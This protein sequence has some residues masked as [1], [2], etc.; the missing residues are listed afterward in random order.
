MK[1]KTFLLVCGIFVLLSCQAKESI[2]IYAYPASIYDDARCSVYQDFQTDLTFTFHYVG[3]KITDLRSGG[4]KFFVELPEELKLLEASLMDGWKKPNEHYTSFPVSPAE[5][6]GRKYLRY[7]L[8]VP[9]SVLQPALTKPLPG[10]MFGGTTNNLVVL[11]VK[12]DKPMPENSKVY[13]ET[14][15]QYPYQGEFRIYPVKLPEGK[16]PKTR[17]ALQSQTHLPNLGYSDSAI[18]EQIRLFR[19]LNISAVNAQMPSGPNQGRKELWKSAGFSFYGGGSLMHVFWS[20]G[21]DEDSTGKAEERDYLAGLDGLRS[22]GVDRR[23]YHMRTFCP[24]AM[25]TPGRYPYR[26]LIRLGR[27]AAEAGSMFLDIDIE[28]DLCIMCYCPECL[29]AFFRFS[30]L[31]PEKLEPEQLVRKY[32]EQWYRF[33]SEQTRLLYQA[34]RNELKGDYPGIQIGANTVL[35][36]FGEDFGNLKYGICEFA[37]DPRLMKESL[38]FIMADTLV[39]GLY[40]AV[41]VDALA[42]SSSLPVIAIPGSSYCVGYSHANFAG[43]RQTA[44]MTGDTYGYGQRYEYHKLGMLHLA[45]NG[46]SALRY[47]IDEACVAKATAEALLIL[48]NV[49]DFYLDG[50][51]ADD[52]IGVTDLTRGASRWQLDS[53]RVRGGIWKHYYDSYCGKVQSRT[54]QLNG[55]YLT[56][57]YNWDPFQTKKWH[58]SMKKLPQGKWY[59]T[60]PVSN[61]RFTVGGREQWSSEELEKGFA[62]SIP[63]ASC[64]LLRLSRKPLPCHGTEDLKCEAADKPVYN[65]YA[66]RQNKQLDIGKFMAEKLKRPLDLIRRYGG[67]KNKDQNRKVEK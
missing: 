53:S 64:R 25:I 45:A 20:D 34:L 47:N 33:R 15:G 44:E 59:L 54:H 16:L 36:R 57:L 10:G 11:M 7:E 31:P 23:A 22:K 5:R 8:P 49:E 27:E 29:N 19:K 55:E 3:G 65:Q 37:E 13:W 46:A 4:T 43:R 62:V 24:Q 51:R 58:L 6:D 9:K 12:P 21:K 60:D 2:R 67:G 56:G 28:A 35:H 32:P 63:K 17:I 61:T 30:K 14:V 1:M 50:K 18:K 41:S 66:W 52:Q 39:G 42:L 38:D 48:S 26:K 40:D